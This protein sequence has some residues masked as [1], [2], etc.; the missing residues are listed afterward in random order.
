MAVW[1]IHCGRRA[2][3]AIK[4]WSDCSTAAPTSSDAIAS[5]SYVSAAQIGLSL[6][7][8]HVLSKWS[9]VWFQGQIFVQKWRAA[10]VE[11]QLD[12]VKEQYGFLERYLSETK[13][14]ACD[15][16]R[17]LL[18]GLTKYLIEEDLQFR[19]HFFLA[20]HRR[21]L[22]CH[23]SDHP[24]YACARYQGILAKVAQLVAKCHQTPSIFRRGQYRG[25]EVI[26]NCCAR[27]HRLPHSLV[28][29]INHK[30]AL[31]TNIKC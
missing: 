3:C 5:L 11:E 31:G 4:C 30:L 8:Q 26:E 6:W 16:V 1:I 19:F 29:I 14:I 28:I 22:R 25:I 12:K 24:R 17:S 7:Q 13:Y 9:I 15:Q 27:M 2:P 20:H 18:H 10:Q 21:P 23:H